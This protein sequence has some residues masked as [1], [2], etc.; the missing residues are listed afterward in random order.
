MDQLISL[1]KELI[2][3]RNDKIKSQV[4]TAFSSYK[5]GDDKRNELVNNIFRVIRTEDQI[6]ALKY[7]IQDEKGTEYISL[8][9]QKRQLEETV[10]VMSNERMG[11]WSS[12]QIIPMAKEIAEISQSIK[13][14]EPVL[15]RD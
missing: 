13:A 7:L 5:D 4:E 1:V 8:V 2:V 11:H 6:V 9:T 14:L 10:L 3:S 12:E 15:L